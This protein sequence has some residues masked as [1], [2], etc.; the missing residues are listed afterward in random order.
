MGQAS[1]SRDITQKRAGMPVDYQALDVGDILTGRNE[2]ATAIKPGYFIAQGA[3]DDD[4]MIND[5]GATGAT[6]LGVA[7]DNET[8]ERTQGAVTTDG[9]VQNQLVPYAATGRF[10]VNCG[11]AA[12]KGGTVYV[13]FAAGTTAVIGEAYNSA[14]TATADA[15]NAK[16]AET[17]TAPGI[18]AVELNMHQV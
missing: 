16:F 2:L 7:V 12:A 11:S 14:D 5:T 1:W 17:I 15:V 9:Y 18:V 3:T 13:R 8:R 6:Y 4:V 10:Y